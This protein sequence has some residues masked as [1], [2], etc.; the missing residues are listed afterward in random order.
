MSFD[1]EVLGAG[2]DFFKL[3]MDPTSAH[4]SMD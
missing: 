2:I 4:A 3:V 1:G